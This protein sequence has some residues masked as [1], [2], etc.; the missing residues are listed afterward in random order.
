MSKNQ[1]STEPHP[2]FT[3]PEKK[4]EAVQYIFDVARTAAA[5]A[6]VHDKCRVYAQFLADSF[7]APAIPPKAE[8]E[9]EPETGAEAPASLG[10]AVAAARAA[11]E[12]PPAS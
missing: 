2:F 5:P 9:P 6:A 4:L 12:A 8:K 1:S 11:A 10:N 3:P 7:V